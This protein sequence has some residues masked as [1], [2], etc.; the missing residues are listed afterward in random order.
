MTTVKT[1][2]PDVTIT[3]NGVSVPDIADV[4][5]GRLTDF[6]GILGGHASQS[7][8]APQGQIAQSE[9]EILAQVYDKLLCLFNQINPDFASGRFQDGIGRIY[10]LNRIPGQGSVVMA[11]CTGK[12]GTRIP[13]GS[14]AQDKAGYLW[15]SVSEATIPASGT[16]KIPFQNTTHGPIA[17]ATG[18]LT[19]IFSS[20]SGWDAITNDTPARV[21]SQVESRIAFETRRRQSVARNGRNTDGAMKAAL[22][23]TQGVTDAYV[24]SNRT[25]ETVTIGTTLYPVKPHSVFICVNGGNDTDI[26]ETIFQ[27]YNPG[28]DMNGDTTFTV[29]DKENYSPPYPQYVMQWQRATPLSVY[30]SVNIDKSLNPPCDITGQVKKTVIRVFNG[31]VE[32]IQRAGIGATL[33]VGKY[34]A[35][36]IAIEPYSVSVVS[37]MIS[38]DGKNWLSA[39]TPGVAQVPVLQADNIHVELK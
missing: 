30:F 38:Q 18:E 15:R 28:A 9:T 5:A 36:I 16:V 24:W 11:T 7:L 14:T 32:G 27:Y 17:C 22:L 4:L 33:N 23:E 35:P 34:Y 13:A 6:V 21:G 26:A 25:R 20:V 8:S 1:A 39:L 31:E 29:Y 12:V 37:V 2:V 19:Q 10:F 3:E